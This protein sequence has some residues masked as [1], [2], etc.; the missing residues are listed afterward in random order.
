MTKIVLILILVVVCSLLWSQDSKLG[1]GISY[2]EPSGICAKG[3]IDDKTAIAMS[4]AWTSENGSHNT[5]ITADYL[6]H[7]N[8]I[9]DGSMG[10]LVA[11]LGLGF[12]S[13]THATSN[14]FSGHANTV[15]LRTPIGFDLLFKGIPLDMFLEFVPM[16]QFQPESRGDFRA[17][18]GIRVWPFK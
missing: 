10:R 17:A 4:A 16:M 3:W 14:D 15:K 2:S 7:T 5:I 6:W 8:P 9:D 1:V 13:D 11:Y 18:V 12:R